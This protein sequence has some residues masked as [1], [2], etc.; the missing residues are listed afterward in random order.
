MRRHIVY[1][2]GGTSLLF[3]YTFETLCKELQWFEWLPGAVQASALLLRPIAFRLLR[4]NEA[5]RGELPVCPSDSLHYALIPALTPPQF[6]TVIVVKISFPPFIQIGAIFCAIQVTRMGLLSQ[7]GLADQCMNDGE[8]PCVCYRNGVPFSEH[9]ILVSHAD[10]V[11][12]HKGRSYTLFEDEAVL[13]SDTESVIA[14]PSRRTDL[15]SVGTGQCP[16]GGLSPGS[17]AAASPLM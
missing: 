11:S 9:P 15:L 4:V 10:F 8:E 17:I 5:I 12:C 2:P 14:V 3:S 7:L 16:P 1:V 6:S 13:I